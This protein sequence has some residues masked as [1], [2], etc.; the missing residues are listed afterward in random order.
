M[1]SIKE[2]RAI[3]QNSEV[4]P[5]WRTQSLEGRINR[6]F[7][8]YLTWI[9]IHLPFT[10]NQITAFG[11]AVYLLGAGLF[12]KHSYAWNLAGVGLVMLSFLLDAVDGELARYRKM[13]AGGGVGGTYVEPVSHDVQYGFVFLPI[14]IGV[15]LATGTLWPLVAGFVAT[16]SKLLFRLLEFRYNNLTRFVSERQGKTY[17]LVATKQETPTSISYFIFRNV[18]TGTGMIFPLLIFSLL[19]HVEWFLYFYG[20][21]FFALWVY[22]FQKQIG[23]VKK[24]IANQKEQM[25][26]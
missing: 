14:G 11:T 9:F 26:L 5:N 22:L 16:T 19:R 10:P 15:S 8:I 21:G 2:L 18:F 1:P 12:L 23:R 4:S 3:C 17:G 24:I 7:S 25:P 6:V 20:A 13:T